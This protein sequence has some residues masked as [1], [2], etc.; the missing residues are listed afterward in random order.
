MTENIPRAHSVCPVVRNK[1]NVA[2]SPFPII[3]NYI[4]VE[5]SET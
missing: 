4:N 2:R 5:H 1:K 3:F